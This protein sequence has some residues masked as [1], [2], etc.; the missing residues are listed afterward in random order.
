MQN[1]RGA[2]AQGGRKGKCIVG[3]WGQNHGVNYLF[4]LAMVSD[5]G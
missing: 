5:V 4:K 3:N 1:R 2:K